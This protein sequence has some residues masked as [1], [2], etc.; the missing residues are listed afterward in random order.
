MGRR[1]THAGISL[2][3]TVECWLEVLILLRGLVSTADMHV[4]AKIL[5]LSWFPFIKKKSH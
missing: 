3:L 1:V 2:Q 5:V 4:I